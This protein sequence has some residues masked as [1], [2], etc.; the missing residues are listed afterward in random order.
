MK[1]SIF[2]DKFFRTALG[3]SFFLHMCLIFKVPNFS[4]AKENTT[5]EI[6]YVEPEKILNNEKES[7]VKHLPA[8]EKKE[9]AENKKA[10]QNLEVK[11]R[12]PL[13]KAEKKEQDKQENKQENKQEKITIK[14]P[15]EEF[16]KKM[17]AL[18]ELP[19]FCDY[20]Q[21]LRGCIKQSI[22]YPYPFQEGEVVVSFTLLRDGS[23]QE[24]A[25]L[26]NLSVNNAYL[27][28]AAVKAVKDAS[29][30]KPFPEDLHIEKILFQ[31]PISFEISN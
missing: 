30:F 13:V 20:Y 25:V 4:F 9:R 23:L 16:Q 3:I 21:Y 22:S 11:E 29:P 10:E 7:I 24:V 5:L 12:I 27:C 18:Y 31:I 14:E 15:R 2:S 28:Y 19:G 17:D 6:N 8:E 1:D 26:K